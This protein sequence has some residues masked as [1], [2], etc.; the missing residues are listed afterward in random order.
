[1]GGQQNEFAAQ[2]ELGRPMFQQEKA[3]SVFQ[4]PL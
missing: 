3:E 1:L 4:H 2:L